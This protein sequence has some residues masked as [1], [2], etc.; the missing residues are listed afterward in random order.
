MADLQTKNA[1]F[2]TPC[3]SKGTIGLPSS[4]SYTTLVLRS[5]PQFRPRKRQQDRQKPQPA[6]PRIKHHSSPPPFS[7]AHPLQQAHSFARSLH[8]CCVLVQSFCS[9]VQYFRVGF[10]GGGEGGRGG[11]EGL[12]EL[13]EGGGE[14][15]GFGV[16]VGEEVGLCGFSV[17]GYRSI[18][19]F[20][21]L[22]FSI[23]QSGHRLL[24]R[25]SR[26]LLGFWFLYCWRGSRPIFAKYV[27]LVL[28]P[29]EQV[30]IVAMS[31]EIV[32]S[33][34]EAFDEGA[35]RRERGLGRGFLGG[36]F[37]GGGGG[38]LEAEEQSAG[39]FEILD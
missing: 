8:A 1:S 9:S 26:W 32:Q 3:Q 38:V 24:Y 25:L 15:G 16:V 23:S 28:E 37:E 31:F 5:E 30:V 14:R 22:L 17:R 6:N 18:R 13:E 39:V 4:V 29:V 27:L 11:F 7:L 20:V 10:Q 34:C 33:V 19:A 36:E 21:G 12:G 2:P 35:L